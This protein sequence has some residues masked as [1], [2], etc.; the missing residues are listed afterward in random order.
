MRLHR[1]NV[2]N[3]EKAIWRK[4][5]MVQWHEEERKVTIIA[6]KI[7]E[8][9]MKTNRTRVELRRFRS[10]SKSCVCVWRIRERVSNRAR[11]HVE[12]RKTKNGTKS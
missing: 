1:C 6:T 12:S 7:S 4:A 5:N 8:K 3:Q 2:F 10:R 9:K 11:A